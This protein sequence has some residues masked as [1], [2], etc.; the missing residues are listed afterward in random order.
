MKKTIFTLNIGNYEPEIINLTYPFIKDYAKKIG[1]DFK[2]IDKAVFPGAPL[3]Y[4]KMQIFELG[5]GND[6][7]IYVDSD[8]LVNPY[9][10]DITEIL[11]EDTVLS[12]NADFA[13][14]RFKYDNYFRRDGRNIAMGNFFTVASHLCT[15]IWE[16]LDGVSYKEAVERIYLTHQNKRLNHAYGYGIDDFV[17]SR[18]LARYGLKYKTF[19]QLL[20]DLGKPNADFMYHDHLLTTEEKLKNIKEK[21]KNWDF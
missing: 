10:F 12:Y 15:E 3:M 1:A 17:T 18:N 6:W 2:I 19:P 14:A 13:D 20:Q 5:R 8:C 21:I 16:P 4:E 11:P 7:N 9:L